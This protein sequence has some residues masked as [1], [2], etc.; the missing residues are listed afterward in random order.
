[1]ILCLAV[2]WGWSKELTILPVAALFPALVVDQ[3]T[4]PGENSQGDKY[5]ISPE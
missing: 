1:M 3:K 2:G 5:I 4:K